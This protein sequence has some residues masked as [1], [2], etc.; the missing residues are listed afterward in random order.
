MLRA[1]CPSNSSNLVPSVDPQMG[2]QITPTNIHCMLFPD[3]SADSATPHQQSL[4]V[5]VYI[6]RWISQTSLSDIETLHQQRGLTHLH[7]DIE[8]LHQQRVLIHLQM[9]RH[10][11]PGVQKLLSSLQSSVCWLIY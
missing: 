6:C 10:C 11:F 1:I 8:T 3:P 7:T 9:V 4:C 2:L 5:S